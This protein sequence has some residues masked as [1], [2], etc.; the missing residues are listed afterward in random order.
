LRLEPLHGPF[1]DQIVLRRYR[2]HPLAGTRT[3]HPIRHLAGFDRPLIPVPWVVEHERHC[4]A[5][6]PSRNLPRY[7]ANVGNPT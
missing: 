4:A 7:A 1:R 5:L 2:K 3:D 6:L